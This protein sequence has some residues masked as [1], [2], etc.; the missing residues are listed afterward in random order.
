MPG[1]PWQDR[2]QYA[3]SCTDVRMMVIRSRRLRLD[4][5]GWDDSSIRE[6]AGGRG[7][8][9]DEVKYTQASSVLQCA[10]E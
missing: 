6:T 8:G 9:S 1:S 3:A 5:D 7:R 2:F 4:E 10:Y